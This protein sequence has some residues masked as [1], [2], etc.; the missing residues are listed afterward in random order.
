MNKPKY[1][2]EQVVNCSRLIND[3]NGY[4][5]IVAS[6]KI[7]EVIEP[8]ENQMFYRYS[9]FLFGDLPF[10]EIFPEYYITVDK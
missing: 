5:R 4:E 7:L 9:V 3:G 8:T 2:M 10:E 6:C 1:D